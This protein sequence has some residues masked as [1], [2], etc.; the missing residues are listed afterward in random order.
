MS[1][2]ELQIQNEL[3]KTWSQREL[4][5][6]RLAA[7]ESRPG[8]SFLDVGCGNGSYVLKLAETVD[9]QGVDIT[10]YE[11]WSAAPDRFQIADAAKLPF[12]DDQFD[13]VACFEV[14]EH[15]ADPV[16]VLKELARVSRRHVIVSVPNC[17]IPE[18]MKASRMTFYHYIDRSHVNFFTGET[19]GTAFDE[20]GISVDESRLINPCNLSALT[21]DIL[22]LPAFLS[23]RLMR[24][25]YFMTCL[26]AGRVDRN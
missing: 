22:R 26:C 6:D 11:N 19:L 18:A 5:P 13:N 14:I 8:K 12:D 23:K 2:G 15:V 4:N 17:E 24:K 9:A 1:A 3:L 16:A 21:A 10:E 20:A 25:Q 7:I